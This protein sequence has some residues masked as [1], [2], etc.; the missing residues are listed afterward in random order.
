MERVAGPTTSLG[1]ILGRSGTYF[2][3]RGAGERAVFSFID[4]IFPQ[5]G[6]TLW[7]RNPLKARTNLTRRTQWHRGRRAANPRGLCAGSHWTRGV[8]PTVSRGAAATAI[9]NFIP[10]TAMKALGGLAIQGLLTTRGSEY[11][12]VDDEVVEGLAD[13]QLEDAETVTRAVTRSVTRRLTEAAS[14][15]PPTPKSTP[16]TE[17]EPVTGRHKEITKPSRTPQTPA[18]PDPQAATPNSQPIP[19]R[20]NPFVRETTR[21]LKHHAYLVGRQKRDATLGPMFKESG[22]VEDEYLT[23]DNGVLWYAPRGQKPTLAIPR[24]L[25]PGVLSLVHNTFGHPGVARM[26]L[27]VREKYS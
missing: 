15:I 23:D 17:T 10:P 26:T 2:L 3:K 7:A 5:P 13:L 6:L 25:I 19:K 21:L 11:A 1:G 18:P 14:Q 24:T 16:H 4:H 20:R 12:N 9:T 22:S 8:P 27:L